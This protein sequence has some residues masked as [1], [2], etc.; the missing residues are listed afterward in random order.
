MATTKKKTH[1]G[2]KPPVQPSHYMGT[3]EIPKGETL[4]MDIEPIPM[5]GLYGRTIE[6][7]HPREFDLINSMNINQSGVFLTSKTN[8]INAIR[9]RLKKLYDKKY[10][11][12]KINPSQ[13][14]IWRV[15]DGLITRP[16]GAAAIKSAAD[17][18]RALKGKGKTGP[19]QNKNGKPIVPLISEL[20]DVQQ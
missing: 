17:K 19:K 20:N 10:I 8:I 6:T 7:T 2:K 4:V 9:N 13:S 15:K 12:K 3:F 14:R 11:I 1:P 5:I 16:G 18:L